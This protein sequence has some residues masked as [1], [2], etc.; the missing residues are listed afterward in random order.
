V[1]ARR[2]SRE[3]AEQAQT[4]ANGVGEREE[5]HKG[6]RFANGI[7]RVLKGN[8]IT[9]EKHLQTKRTPQKNVRHAISSQ[10]YSKKI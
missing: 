5:K 1:L 6:K 10:G 2:V 8:E 7:G 4:A 3:P 9:P